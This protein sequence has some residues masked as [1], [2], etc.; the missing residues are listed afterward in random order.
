MTNLHNNLLIF[1][2][3]WSLIITLSANSLYGAIIDN[4]VTNDRQPRRNLYRG[5]HKFKVPEYLNVSPDHYASTIFST[6]SREPD[7]SF[8]Y[9]YGTDNGI[10]VKQESTGYGAN[11]VVRGGYSY[12]GTDNKGMN[13]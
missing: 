11:K 3:F 10:K 12:V 9:E 5:N 8:R 1:K 2:Y 4:Y 13:L 7:G 6:D